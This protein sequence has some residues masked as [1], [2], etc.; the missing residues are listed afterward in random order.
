MELVRSNYP[1]GPFVLFGISGAFVFWAPFNNHWIP[2]HNVH[3]PG[4]DNCTLR[5]GGRTLSM[6]RALDNV[7][8]I[9]VQPVESLSY[10]CITKK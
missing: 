7:D 4:M 9:V 5:D 3:A 1:R 10:G 6:P 8:N 2:V